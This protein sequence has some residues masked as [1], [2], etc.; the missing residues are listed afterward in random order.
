MKNSFDKK[1]LI[2]LFETTTCWSCNRNNAV[3]FHH[4]LGRAGTSRDGYSHSSPLNAAPLCRICHSPEGRVYLGLPPITDDEVKI[5]F[6][7]QT[8]RMLRSQRYTL[9]AKDQAFMIANREYYD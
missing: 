6:L 9:T 3:D 8:L 5:A 4:I 7:D 1:V 2:R